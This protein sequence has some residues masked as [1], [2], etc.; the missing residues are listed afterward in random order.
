MNINRRIEAL[1]LHIPPSSPPGALYVPVKQLGGALYVSGQVPMVDGKPVYTGK[2][3]SERSIEYGQEAAR[4]CV[5]NM[6]AALKDFT[7]DLN[8]VKGV[9][10]LLAFVNSEVGFWEQ[11][12]VVNAASQLLFDVF[13][14]DGR[15]ARSAVGT[16]Q[17]PM[18]VTVEIEGIFELR[19]QEAE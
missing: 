4:L 12:I 17:L 11:H 2:V 19:E 5:I 16:N 1:G 13:G 6:L 10:K 15:H 3:G 8:K 7:G 14:E 18:D 9:V